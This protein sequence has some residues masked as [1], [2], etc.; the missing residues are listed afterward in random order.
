MKNKSLCKAVSQASS[1]KVK[2][3][4]KAMRIEAYLGPT[5]RGFVKCV[6]HG[7]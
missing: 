4:H 1:C 3:V 6:P 7:K 2:K 5:T